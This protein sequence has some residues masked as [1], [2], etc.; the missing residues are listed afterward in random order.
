MTNR[1]DSK[2]SVATILS[3]CGENLEMDLINQRLG[4]K[5]PSLVKNPSTW[6]KGEWSIKPGDPVNRT[7]DE[8]MYL[9]KWCKGLS[10]KQSKW[11]LEEQLHFWITRLFPIRSAFEEFKKL[12]YWSVIDCQLTARDRTLPS[13]QFRLS[14]DALAKLSKIAIDLDFTIYRPTSY[15]DFLG[16]ETDRESE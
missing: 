11:K 8:R 7:F 10:P 6:R 5:E 16:L 9:D 2:H 13:I 3:I 14:Q 12:G 4:V 1:I 15:A